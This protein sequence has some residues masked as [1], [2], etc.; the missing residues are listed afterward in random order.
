MWV[1]HEDATAYATW[2]GGRLP[3]DEEWQY[4]A[5]GSEGRA[6]PWGAEFDPSKCNHDGRDLCS[7]TANPVGE[8]WCGCQD[9]CGNAWEWTGPV[10]DDGMHQFALIRGGCYYHAP[11]RWHAAGGARRCDFHWKMQLMNEAVNRARTVG[12]RCVYEA[13]S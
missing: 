8:S 2:A 6:W 13:S 12:F 7:V 11:H 5:A 3:T 1:S 4:V 9:L 10:L